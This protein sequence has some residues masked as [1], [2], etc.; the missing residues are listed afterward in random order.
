MF[1]KIF[2]LNLKTV[3]KKDLHAMSSIDVTLTPYG[4]KKKKKNKGIS[5]TKENTMQ[6]Q[7]RS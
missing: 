4:F 1:F 5:V 6:N 7:E 3:N 2:N